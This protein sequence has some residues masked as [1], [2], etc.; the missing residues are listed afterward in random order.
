[1]AQQYKGTEA[2]APSD[3]FC[4]ISLALMSDP[5]VTCDGHTY[6]RIAIE[7]WFEDRQT[8]PLTNAVLE[9]KTLTPNIALRK[10]IEE[11]EDKHLLL[12]RRDQLTIEEDPIG[13]GSFK[14]VYRGKLQIPG[15]PLPSDVAV[16]K[17]RQGNIVDETKML[18]RLG[19]H[20]RLVRFY[21]QC[22]QVREQDPFI[23]TEFAEFGSLSDVIGRMSDEGTLSKLTM[24]H[25]IIMM[26]QICEGM[27]ALSDAKVVH[28]DL[29]ARNVLLFQYNP[30][31]PGSTSVK[32]SDFGLSMGL[33]GQSYAYGKEN[34]PMPIRYVPPEVIQR[35]KFSEKSDVWAFGITMWEILNDCKF[36][37]YDIPED[38]E[39]ITF[40]L[41]GGRL[42]APPKCPDILWN[43]M[44]E[45]WQAQP[46][47]RPSFSE[48]FNT[49]ALIESDPAL[50][51]GGLAVVQ[52][53]PRSKYA[54][55]LDTQYQLSL[56]E[57]NERIK[58]EQSK[59]IALLKQEKEAQLE[60]VRQQLMEAKRREEA[61][62]KKRLEAEEQERKR[63][64]NE[65][66]R[67]RQL[68]LEQK[69]RAE[70]AERKRR[71]E[72]EQKQRAEAAERKRRQELEQ[73]QRAE[74]K[75][76]AEAAEKKRRQEREQE[77]KREESNGNAE[78]WFAAKVGLALLGLPLFF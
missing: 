50:K 66:A 60:Q 7:I 14:T 20:P 16:M 6:E 67:K 59:Q 33:Y 15:A 12:L 62:R 44:Q 45:C 11:W 4:P 8:S 37:Y 69:Q 32:V 76:R 40:V 27:K 21:G 72:L 2:D 1:M 10:S 35:R 78:L 64:A 54:I 48:L 65:A 71:Q 24:H 22:K 55:Q 34:K 57:E 9:N 56:E 17:I 74:E 26:A 25:K 23:V 53:S 29:A 75:Q 3:F 28:G 41:G 61:E 51:S 70:A 58:L 47:K 77:P 31:C 5:V 68:E 49:F 30:S 39:V 46:S 38:K 42:T 73:K 13:V 52:H 19:R 36:P 18:L 43:L 63:Q